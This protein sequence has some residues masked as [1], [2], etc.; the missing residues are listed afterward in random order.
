MPAVPL[1]C[2]DYS[3]EGGRKSIAEKRAFERTSYE[4]RQRW[5]KENLK[6]YVISLRLSDDSDL[7]EYIERNKKEIGTTEIFRKAL[8]S[9]LDKD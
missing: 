2:F 3:I 6:R 8:K 7:I 5:D 9:Q 4:I 1:L